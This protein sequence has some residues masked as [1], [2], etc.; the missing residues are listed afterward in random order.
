MQWFCINLPYHLYQVSLM[1]FFFNSRNGQWPK[2]SVAQHSEWYMKILG[3]TMWLW[4]TT[5]EKGSPGS[6]I[7]PPPPW[8]CT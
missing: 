6:Y 5:K 3:Q 2:L 4:E 8:V 7:Y 1:F